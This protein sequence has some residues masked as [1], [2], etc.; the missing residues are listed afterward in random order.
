MSF[1]ITVLAPLYALFVAIS[2]IFGL[3]AGDNTAKVA[4]PYNPQSG[5]VWEYDNVEDPYISLTKTEIKDGEQ[6]FYFT[7]NTRHAYKEFIDG[8]YL[9]LIFTDENGN[10]VKYYAFI[11]EEGYTY[12]SKVKILEPDEYIEYVYDINPQTPDV[13]YRWTSDIDCEKYLKYNPNTFAEKNSYTVVYDKNSADSEIIEMYFRC[14][15]VSEGNDERHRLTID[16]SS[17][18]GVPVEKNIEIIAAE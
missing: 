15:P 4:L 10:S 13:L 16:F 7:G 9:D 3:A 5:L 12:N 14:I 2:S 17:G 18:E 8:D 6:I 11:Y 1:I